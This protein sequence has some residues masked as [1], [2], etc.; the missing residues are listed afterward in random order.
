MKNKTIIILLSILF[1]LS[2][3]LTI[4]GFIT[5]KNNK[6]EIPKKENNNITYEYY[7]DDIKVNSLPNNIKTAEDIKIDNNYI[8][9]N[10]NCTNNI[11]GNFDTTNWKFIP[12]GNNG[13]CKLYF[14]KSKYEVTLTITNGMQDENNLKY[15]DRE[16]DGIFKIIPDTGY[17]FKNCI[18]AN[19]KEAK[20]NDDNNTLNINAITSDVACTVYFEKKLLNINVKVYNGTGNTSEKVL[21]GENK[22]IVVDANDGFSN[23]RINCTNGQNATYTNN[24]LNFDKVTNDTNC[25]VTFNRSKINSYN[26]KI[27]NLNEFKD[28]EIISGKENN[29]VSNNKDLKITLKSNNSD[30]KPKLNCGD[31]IP[32]VNDLENTNTREFSF[33]SVT[34]DI[35]CKIE[36]E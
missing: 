21:F 28:I 1:F 4:I 14:V 22:S 32:V 11:T 13:V 33:L 7:V 35:T 36:L 2:S 29:Y 3:F 16:N 5:N 6:P 8:F 24:S 10:Y 31:V 17:I 26:I 20:W 9:K 12:N 18:C 23:P 27:T 25:T 30:L 34:K 19:N 15:I